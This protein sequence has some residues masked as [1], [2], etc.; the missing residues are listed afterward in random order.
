MTKKAVEKVNKQVAALLP[1]SMKELEKRSLFGSHASFSAMTNLT[2]SKLESNGQCLDDVQVKQSSIRSTQQGLFAQ[3]PIKK[4]KLIVPAP[5]YALLREK[6]CAASD[7]ACASGGT[8][9]LMHCFGHQ[10]SSLA[11]CPLSAAAFIQTGSGDKGNAAVQWSSRLN[12]KKFHKL[13]VDELSEV[14]DLRATTPASPKWR[15]TSRFLTEVCCE[16]GG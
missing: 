1:A 8:A 6:T 2:I 4:G 12:M 10:D 11:L 7:E 13:S 15:L 5:L 16:S 9:N 3:R 14:S